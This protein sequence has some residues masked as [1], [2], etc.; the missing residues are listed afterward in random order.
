MFLVCTGINWI[1]CID[2]LDVIVYSLYIYEK[3]EGI[4]IKNKRAKLFLKT[5]SDLLRLA[6]NDFYK[7]Q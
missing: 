6:V 4:V 3:L 5:I 7:T 2:S 1:G